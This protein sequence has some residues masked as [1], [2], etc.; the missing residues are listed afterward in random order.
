MATNRGGQLLFFF[1]H[2]TLSRRTPREVQV[3]VEEEGRTINGANWMNPSC[4]IRS[5]SSSTPMY[6]PNPSYQSEFFVDGNFLTKSRSS[7]KAN[8][9]KKSQNNRNSYNHDHFLPIDSSCHDDD[10][11]HDHATN[12]SLR[13]YSFTTTTYYRRDGKHG[14]TTTK[15]T[16][17]VVCRGRCSI[18][19]GYSI[20]AK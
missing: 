18:I 3:H 17:S 1:S 5:W 9:V 20:A 19:D 14:T 6:D 11:G 15:S 8:Q 7:S 2:S 13:S 10:S 16:N 4:R 12:A